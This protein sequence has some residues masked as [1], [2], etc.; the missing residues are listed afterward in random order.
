M[1]DTLI[2]KMIEKQNP[3]VAGLDPQLS[4][5]P[6]EIKQDAVHRYGRT[7]EGAAYALLQFNRGLIDALYDVV[8]A[9]KPQSAY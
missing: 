5:I 9:V 6:D 3:T 1:V 2:Q 4:Y 8:P 7:L